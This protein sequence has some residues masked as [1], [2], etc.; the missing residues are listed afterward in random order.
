MQLYR[1]LTKLEL[2]TLRGV[3]E[4][5]QQLKAQAAKAEVR[6]KELTVLALDEAP[7][8]SQIDLDKGC[9][10]YPSPPPDEGVDK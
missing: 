10:N 2:A 8:G 6:L 7:E 5:T 9:I 4:R 1:Q 3:L